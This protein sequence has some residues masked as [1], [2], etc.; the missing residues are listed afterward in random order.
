MATEPT[1]LRKS[2]DGLST[3]VEHALGND[4]LSGHLFVFFNKKRT[5]VRCL[6]WDRTGYCVL[7]KRLARGRF[8]FT[9]QLEAGSRIVEIESVELALILE[10]IELK[11]ALRSARWRPTRTT[12][13][14]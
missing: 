10:G 7:A 1:D 14:A 5:Q 2:F 3:A 4:P 12:K 9:E 11:G 8:R 13:A 6:F